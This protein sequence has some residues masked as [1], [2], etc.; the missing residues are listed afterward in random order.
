MEITG[1]HM[2]TRISS[3]F[4]LYLQMISAFKACTYNI[5]GWFKAC[6]YN[7]QHAASTATL[8]GMHCALKHNLHL[9]QM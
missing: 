4:L 5:Q 8:E 1:R 7:I 3:T 6:T 2:D 9:Q